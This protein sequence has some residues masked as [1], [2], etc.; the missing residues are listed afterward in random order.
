MKEVASR[1]GPAPVTVIRRAIASNSSFTSSKQVSKQ[2]GL[3]RQETRVLS[4][5]LPWPSTCRW[6]KYVVLGRAILFGIQKLI[7]QR[8]N[9][10]LRAGEPTNHCV[11]GLGCRT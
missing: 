2:L 4:N 6:G 8:K 5:Y 10:E 3:F 7:A 11:L 1:Y 9:N